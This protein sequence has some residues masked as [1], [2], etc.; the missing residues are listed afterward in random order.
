MNFIKSTYLRLL[1]YFICAVCIYDI[2]CTINHSELLYDKELN[3]IAKLLIEQEELQT[4]YHIKHSSH[5]IIVTHTNVAKLVL[6]KI[7]GLVAALEIFDWL[8]H[9]KHSKIAQIVIF[10]YGIYSIII[11][12]LFN[13]GIN[14][15]HQYIFYIST[16]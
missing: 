8:I 16:I 1:V 4:L 7:L 2:Y 14:Y 9:S 10:F 12:T 13:T 5:T 6:F 11:I 15:E 3:P